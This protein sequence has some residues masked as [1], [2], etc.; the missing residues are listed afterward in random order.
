[1]TTI[2]SGMLSFNQTTKICLIPRFYQG[3][4]LLK[5]L[6]VLLLATLL[7]VGCCH[8]SVEHQQPLQA[9]LNSFPASFRGF[10]F[11]LFHCAFCRIS[12]T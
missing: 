12:C 8:V 3:A 7:F 9:K 11:Y 5:D 4:Q 6:Q 2:Y 10:M 1:M